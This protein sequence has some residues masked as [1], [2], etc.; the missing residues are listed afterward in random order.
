MTEVKERKLSFFAFGRKERRLVTEPINDTNPITVQ[1]LGVCSALAVTSLM[2]PSIV[3]SIAVLF[4]V[5]FSSFFTSLLRNYIPSQVRMIVQLVIIA[6]LVT[7]VELFLKAYS[8]PV[9]KQ[10]SVFIGLIITNC[11]PMGR[12]EAYAMANSPWKSFL[13]GVGNSLGYGIILI[14]ISFIRELLGKGS[15]MAGSPLEV[16]LI[17]NS[18]AY[19][20]NTSEVS[21]LNWYSNNNLMS[22]PVAAM[23]ILAIIIW[24]Q[25]SSNRKLINIS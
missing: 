13:D 11:I 14:V 10:L 20:I 24:I 22:L 4:V 15:L 25:R 5:A 23:F 19:L 17:G 7:V 2:W 9:W 8:F 6:F 21:W 18:S 12:L 3:M 16:K 1:I